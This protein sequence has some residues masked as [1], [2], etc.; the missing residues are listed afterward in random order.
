MQDF[1]L[2]LIRKMNCCSMKRKYPLQWLEDIIF[3]IEYQSTDISKEKIKHGMSQSGID[4]ILAT[5]EVEVTAIRASIQSDVF[6]AVSTKKS[7]KRLA[8][9]Y[10]NSLTYYM[11][12][13]FE[14]NEACGELSPQLRELSTVLLE[15]LD[16]IITFVRKNYSL[17]NDQKVPKF[18]L[19]RCKRKMQDH[20]DTLKVRLKSLKSEHSK[21][22]CSIV[23]NVL[24][25]FVKAKKHP[26]QVTFNCTQ[27]RL[28]L[29]QKL[30]RLD[31]WET[32]VADNEYPLDKL[33]IYM[34]FN[35]KSYINYLI[36]CID[37]TVTSSPDQ[38]GALWMQYKIIKQLHSKPSV[39]YNPTYYGVHEILEKWFLS[40][41]E[42]RKKFIITQSKEPNK[43]IDSVPERVAD[44][45]KSKVKVQLSSDQI[46]LFL[47]AA[48]E[49]RLLSA[50]SMTEVFRS[51]VPHL[52]TPNRDSLSF[53]G[54]RIQ[55]YNP[56]DTDKE[57]IVAAL[58]KMIEKIRDY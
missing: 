23:L 30:E 8:K 47:R 4:A 28:D 36:S 13:F 39:I 31:N 50:R 11:N 22:V 25:D 10:Y 49:M 54:V 29:L 34:N 1:R 37:N 27:Y 3:F 2:L 33:L 45:V 17:D 56:E 43:K 58:Q 48:D 35:A 12:L 41:I 16:S 9:Y 52:A 51:I 42:C 18:Y 19:Q 20:I 24:E 6:K 38:L 21:T 14:K 32:S 44:K 40:E 15:K 57:V 5:A 26:F 7:S 55:S 53:Q 46:A